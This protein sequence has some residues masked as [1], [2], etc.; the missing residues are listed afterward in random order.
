MNDVYLLGAGAS[1][2]AEIPDAI[3]MTRKIVEKFSDN[4]LYSHQEKI[5]K[6]V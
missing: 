1:V 3:G 2:E 4:P 6:F 5:L